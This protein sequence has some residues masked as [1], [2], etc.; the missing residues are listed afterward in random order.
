MT[1]FLDAM[2]A[3]LRAGE[4]TGRATKRKRQALARRYEFAKGRRERERTEAFLNMLMRTERRALEL[5][6]WIESR[7]GLADADSDMNRM[8]QWARAQLS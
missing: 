6:N 4:K 3:D 7:E 1:R 2:L 5:R 8:M